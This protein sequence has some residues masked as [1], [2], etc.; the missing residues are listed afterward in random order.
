MNVKYSFLS[1]NCTGDIDNVLIPDGL[2][3]VRG[4]SVPL[5]T[6]PLLLSFGKIRTKLSIIQ[7]ELELF[8]IAYRN[9]SYFSDLAKEAK[10]SSLCSLPLPLVYHNSTDHRH[11]TFWSHVNDVVTKF[12]DI[13]CDRW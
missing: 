6:C 8:F 3:T 7:K 5:Y 11:T 9:I 12:D 2:F 4:Q 10:C 13:G 1:H